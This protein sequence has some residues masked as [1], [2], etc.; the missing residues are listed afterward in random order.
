LLVENIQLGEGSERFGEEKFPSRD[1]LMQFDAECLCLAGLC[2]CFHGI[3]DGNIKCKQKHSKNWQ[4]PDE[5]SKAKIGLEKLS[6][7]FVAQR[8]KLTSATKRDEFAIV[9]VG[10]DEAKAGFSPFFGQFCSL[11]LKPK[12]E[13]FTS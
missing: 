9:F 4:R 6:D 10:N 13:R 5:S 8:E 1:I 12:S 3:L 7:D 11:L 2:G